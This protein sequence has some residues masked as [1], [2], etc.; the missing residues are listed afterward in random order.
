M[1][2]TW[3]GWGGG[4]CGGSHTDVRHGFGWAEFISGADVLMVP[5]KASSD[6][7]T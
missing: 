7:Y 6:P 4:G 5:I 3:G 1:L 2:F